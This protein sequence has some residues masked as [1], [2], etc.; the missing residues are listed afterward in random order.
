[1]LALSLTPS[2]SASMASRMLDCTLCVHCTLWGERKK[3]LFCHSQ[4]T[5][6]HKQIQTWRA[7]CFYACS[8][9]NFHE[10]RDFSCCSIPPANHFPHFIWSLKLSY[11][12]AAVGK[13]AHQSFLYITLLDSSIGSKLNPIAMV[14]T[15]ISASY[16]LPITEVSC[17]FSVI[18]IN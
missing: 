8:F 18:V 3:H 16:I 5:V 4:Q 12:C 2:D 9:Y 13:Y 11:W 1:M 17:N 7:D 15:F 6:W 10:E 14:T